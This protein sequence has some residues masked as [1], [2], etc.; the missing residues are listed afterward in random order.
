MVREKPAKETAVQKTIAY[1]RD[2]QYQCT[3][4]YDATKVH[5]LSKLSKM[6]G[7]SSSTGTVCRRLGIIKKDKKGGYEWLA[8]APDREMALLILDSMLR[9]T[10]RDTNIPLSPEWGAISAVLAEI[11]NKLSI[12]NQNTEIAL[13]R[14]KNKQIEVHAMPGAMFKEEEQKHRDRIYLFGKIMPVVF[15]KE[16][17]YTAHN[18]KNLDVLNET[19]MGIVDAA[20]EKLYNK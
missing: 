9:K 13:S 4:P 10:K 16:Y 6:H 18:G 3:I 8:T 12:S 19:I 2:I 15:E 7:V 1:L 11:S 20:I 5:T 14:L 17:D